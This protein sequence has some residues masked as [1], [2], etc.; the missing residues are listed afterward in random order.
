MTLRLDRVDHIHIYVTDRVAAEKWYHD[1][2]GLD[3]Y[4]K[5]EEWA[6]PQGP[7]MLCNDCGSVMLALFERPAEPNRAVIAFGVSGQEFVNWVEH[8]GKVLNEAPEPVDHGASW[9]VYFYDPDRNPFEIT[10][11][12]YD[13]V[14]SLKE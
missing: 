4:A 6:S 14:K 12:D 13:V 9:S 3:R 2:F 5:L 10:T 7:L 11:Y 1:V 8:L